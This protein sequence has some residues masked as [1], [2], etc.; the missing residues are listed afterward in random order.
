MDTGSRSLSARPHSPRSPGSRITS[1]F[2]L[3][4]TAAVS[5]RLAVAIG[6]RSSRLFRRIGLSAAPRPV[7]GALPA[8]PV[9]ERLDESEASIKFGSRLEYS[10]VSNSSR[11]TARRGVRVESGG[12]ICWGETG[13]EGSAPGVSSGS[14]PPCR[15]R[16]KADSLQLA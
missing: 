6:E 4:E 3:K 12:N 1:F 7:D 2:S 13:R 8:E 10:P 11:L 9:R 5:V 14:T 15:L 16:G